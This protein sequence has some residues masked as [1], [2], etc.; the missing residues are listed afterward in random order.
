MVGKESK[1]EEV[2]SEVVSEE[3]TKEVSGEV[4]SDFQ[5]VPLGELFG[6][7]SVVSS[8]INEV[9][10][11]EKIVEQEKPE[12]TE[13]VVETETKEEE[14]KVEDEVIKPSWDDDENPYKKKAAEFEKRYRDTQVWGNKAHQKLKEFG[15]DNDVEEQ[16]E[17]QKL[18]QFAFN[19][20]D[21][22]SSRIAMEMYGEQVV[23]DMIVGENA[24]YNKI[25]EKHPEVAQR[26]FYA[27]APVMEAIKIVK[28]F[29]FFDKYGHDVEKIPD[30]IRKDLEKEIRE[31]VTQELQK[32]LS[33]KEEM[34]KT[35]SKVT[36]K[37]VKDESGSFEP[38]PL[39][40][41]FG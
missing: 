12:E 18:E 21:R 36:S 29:A 24:P 30:K 4:V 27:D 10:P 23:K 35:L 39:G 2:K 22:V 37:D 3:T 9:M 40:A 8:K 38:T 16:T 5:P 6:E 7:P 13:K 19:E 31:K 41:L 11:E 28:E 25:L 26:V 17:Q 1:M 15:I 20:R 33:K 14:P 34:P 32:K